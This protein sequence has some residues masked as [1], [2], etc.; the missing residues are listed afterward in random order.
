VPSYPALDGKQVVRVL[1]SLGFYVDRISSTHYQMVKPAHP[2]PVPV[3]VH[4]AKTLPTGTF[5]SI[6]R[7]AGLTPKQF[8]QAC[9]N[10]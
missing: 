10:L 5:R 4:A 7:Q 6:L 8:F 3:P 1:E 2:R 9:W